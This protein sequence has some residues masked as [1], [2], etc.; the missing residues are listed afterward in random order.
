VGH[1][2]RAMAAHNLI[3]QPRQARPL[4]PEIRRAMIA[5]LDFRKSLAITSR[6]GSVADNRGGDANRAALRGIMGNAAEL[7]KNVPGYDLNVQE[8]PRTKPASLMEKFRYGARES[9]KA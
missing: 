9:L 7:W 8:D 6:R 4:K 3:I 5:E 1:P 2:C